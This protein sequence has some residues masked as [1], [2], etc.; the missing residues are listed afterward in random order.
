MIDALPGVRMAGENADTLHYLKNMSDG[1]MHDKRWARN[2]GNRTAWGHNEVPPQ[3]FSCVAQHMIETINP[4]KL[5]TGKSFSKAEERIRKEDDQTIVGFKTI[6]FLS[7]PESEDNSL[8]EFVRENFPCSKIVINYTSNVTR[9]SN[10]AWL[11][12]R[13]RNLTLSRLREKNTRLRKISTMLGSRAYMLDSAVW[14][15]NI[16]ALNEMVKWLGFSEKCHF[17]SLLAFNVGG[18]GYRHGDTAMKMQYG[19][20]QLI[21]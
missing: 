2:G 16:S 17:A 20:Q 5:E 12:K 8:I 11:A 1:V 7:G 13:E 19:C 15:K 4:P 14:L 6:R 10:S 18:K 9:Q 21:V 3:S